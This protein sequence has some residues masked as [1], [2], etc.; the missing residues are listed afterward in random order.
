[1]AILAGLASV[2]GR[3]AGRLLNTTLGWATILLFGKVPQRKQTLLL[4]IVLGSLGWVAL[5]LG[6]L[7]PDVGAL[8]IAAVPLPDF[9]EEGW[10]RLA[11]LA[12]AVL[13]P[14]VV[15][16]AAVFVSE[17]ES[18]P[19]GQGLVK[20]LLRGYPFTLVL[21]LT[22]VILAGVGT[23]RKLRAMSRRWEDT[24]VPVIVK[25]GAYDR[26]LQDLRGV[27]ERAGL[28]P[29]VEPAPRLVSAPPRLLDAVAGR[30]LGSLVPD[31][32]MLIRAEGL[33][34]LVYPSDLA[35]S[36][37]KGRVAAARAAIVSELLHAPAYLTT[38]AEA[39]EVE[40]VMAGLAEGRQP[41]VAALAQALPELDGRL[42][43]LVVPFDEWETLYRKRLQVERDALRAGGSAHAQPAGMGRDGHGRPALSEW[44]VAAGGLGLV[45][46]D[47]LLL[48]RGRRTRTRD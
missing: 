19:A 12:G 22:I 33:E 16:A 4:L 40:D 9:V 47:V 44:A 10:I 42:S 38:T 37:T 3:F 13:L 36:G 45:A 20:A 32:L 30:G 8:L 2:L 35:M 41:T 25:P 31:Q 39:Q 24:H 5:V 11:M 18:R 23:F 15:G 17:A 27:L 14:L 48:L 46:L 43:T 1:M 7:L 28:E 29:A 34:I 21:A 6:V 26:V